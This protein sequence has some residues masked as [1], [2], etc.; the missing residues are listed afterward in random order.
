[1]PRPR[2]AV[3]QPRQERALAEQAPWRAAIAQ[4]PAL[5]AQRERPRTMLARGPLLLAFLR[6][7]RNSARATS[8]SLQVWLD[9]QRQM[10]PARRRKIRSEE[11]RVGKECRAGWWREH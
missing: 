6:W 8:E 1:M 11:R 10:I 5:R 3:L 7:A 2:L 9:C 4:L